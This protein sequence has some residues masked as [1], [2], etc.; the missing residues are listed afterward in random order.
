MRVHSAIDGCKSA[1][2]RYPRVKKPLQKGYWALFP[3]EVHY[4]RPHPSE[5]R[6]DAFT[7]IYST[8]EWRA[9]ES[10][11]GSGSTMEATAGVRKHLPGLLCDLSVR[12]FLDAPCGDFHWMRTIQLPPGVRYIGADIVPDLVRKLQEEASGPRY[13]FMAAD[14]VTG[15]LPEADLWMCR[16]TLF[17]LPNADIASVLRRFRGGKVKYVLTTNHN[18]CHRNLDVNFGGFRYINLRKPPFNLPKPLRQFDEY[19]GRGPPCVLALWSR[20]Q[21]PPSL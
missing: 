17:H 18:F 12:T 20:E 19:G 2:S 11:S 10:K 3:S 21:I 7:Q 15:P 16:A 13:T 14:I 5:R 8:N 1:L 6:E 4:M 9:V